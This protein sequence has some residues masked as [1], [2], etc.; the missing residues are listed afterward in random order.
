M[1]RRER[2]VVMA[3]LHQHTA[4]TEVVLLSGMPGYASPREQAIAHMVVAGRVALVLRGLR[5]GLL[6][7]AATTVLAVAVPYIKVG[8]HFGAVHIDIA[9]GRGPAASVATHFDRAVVARVAVLLEDY[10][11]NAGRSF[12]RELGRGIVDNLDALY[13]L[14]GQLLE[15]LGAVI[16]GQS[17]GLAVNPHLHAFVSTQGDVS[18][19]VHVYRGYVLEYIGGCLAGI[20]HQLAYIETLAVYL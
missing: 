5:K 12:S 15:Y 11:D 8:V 4:Q 20:G 3:A 9:T 10:V 1:V 7:L 16:A 19:V 2:P 14:C 17:A 6:A 13:A 18:V